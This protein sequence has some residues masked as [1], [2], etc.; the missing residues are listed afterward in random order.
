MVPLSLLTYLSLSLAQDAVRRQVKER[1]QSSAEM[2]AALV[3]REMESLAELVNSYAL[4]LK[5]V[6]SL[7]R[8]GGYDKKELRRNLEELAGAR[9]GIGVAFVTDPSGVLIDIIPRTPSIVGDD[10]RFF[11][12]CTGA[13]RPR[14]SPISPRPTPPRPPAMSE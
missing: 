6:E 1:L 5:V 10:F 7:D 8:R 2:S 4:R 11:A 9:E 3:Q 13:S 12:T 14:E